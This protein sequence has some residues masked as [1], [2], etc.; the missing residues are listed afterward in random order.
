VLILSQIGRESENRTGD[1]RPQLQDLKES[2]GL[3]ENADIVGALFREEFYKPE[4]EDLHGIGELI[5]LKNR[6]GPI[7]TIKL[8]WLA[9]QTRY[10]NSPQDLK[11]APDDGRLPYADR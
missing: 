1:K 10:G 2:G 6:N 11:D 5:L 4:R 8:V 9:A 3:E 7:G